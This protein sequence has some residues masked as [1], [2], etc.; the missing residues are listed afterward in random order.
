M[1]ANRFAK[2]SSFAA[3]AAALVATL[4]AAPA[5][6]R[7]D[8]PEGVRGR[9]AW[10][11]AG[12]VETRSGNE[13]RARPDMRE[14]GNRESPRGWERPAP[15]APQAASPGT[16]QR[17]EWR[18][19][20]GDGRP[21]D[22][23]WRARDYPATVQADAP[24]ARSEGRNRSYADPDRNRTY[25][26]GRRD[27]D[28]DRSDWR[29]DRDRSE[30]RADW[31]RDDDRRRETWR[32]TPSRGDDWRRDGRNGYDRRNYSGQHRRWDNGWRND[33]RYDWSSYRNS[34]RHV[35]RLGHY[36]A[37][38]RG[39]YYRPLSIGFVLDSLFFSSRYWINDP[40]EYRLPAAY[41][42][43][44]WVRYYDDA[45]MVDIY[46]GEVVDVIRDFF[47]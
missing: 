42:P 9:G 30:N 41:G 2:K 13:A 38:Y 5:L 25:R 44:R 26:D 20:N 4:M 27:R 36:N 34:H 12:Q 10:N 29:R 31:R 21:A 28:N 35:Y 24:P 18:N 6:A 37:P 43:Y 7:P 1:T 47:W 11:R 14:P 33:R 8:D 46:S 22:R 40:W 15:G 19:R 32:N 45:L 3:L 17:G 23:S 16:A 39:Y